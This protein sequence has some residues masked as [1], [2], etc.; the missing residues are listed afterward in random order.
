MG[1]RGV[2]ERSSGIGFRRALVQ[3]LSELRIAKIREFCVVLSRFNTHAF[4]N[5]ETNRMSIRR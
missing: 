4:G 1:E 2:G 5:I 3:I